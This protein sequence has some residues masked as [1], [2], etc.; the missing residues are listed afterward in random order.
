MRTEEIEMF[1]TSLREMVRELGMLNRNSSGT[2]LSPLQ[3]H[4]L[5]ELNK[6]PAG[7]TELA[8]RLCTE[9]SSI[10]R[11]I[12]SLEKVGLVFRMQDKQDGRAAN[13][14]LSESGSKAHETI[15]NNANAFI[16]DALLLAS[17][18]EIE[19]ITSNVIGLTSALK[20][21]R[22]QRELNIVIRPITAA[23]NDHIAE[24]IRKS[25]RDNKIDHLEGVSLHDPVLSNLTD[26]YKAEKSGY[27]VAIANG[28]LVGG[29]GIAQLQGAGEE[30]CEMQKL[31]L[32]KSVI[33]IG[34]GR[35][36]IALSIEKAKEFGY[37]Y[38]YLETLNELSSA[39]SLYES[40]GFKHLDGRLGNTGHGGCGI[41]MLKALSNII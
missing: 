24:V 10:S 8:Q 30:Y 35:R 7:V 16:S 25:F 17:E 21:A 18:S 28:T 41:C 32:D 23:D 13:F 37:S 36:L 38:C 29:V 4:V 2:D 15:N 39:V 12:R 1:R 3:S 40:F 9:K 34:L 14:R 5:I 20:N 11:T 22:K 6:N 33:G 27:W 31:Y 19:S 26:A